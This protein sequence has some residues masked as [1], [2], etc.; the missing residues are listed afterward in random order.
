MKQ[1]L[2]LFENQIRKYTNKI[3]VIDDLFNRK[4]DCD[5]LLDQNLG[6]KKSFYK[7]LVNVALQT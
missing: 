1:D 3:M 7:N 6:V 2:S 5:I 4:H